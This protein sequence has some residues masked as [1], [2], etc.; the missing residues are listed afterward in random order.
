M[1][2][3]FRTLGFEI[4]EPVPLTELL[5]SRIP[6]LES[7]DHEERNGPTR[8]GFMARLTIDAGQMSRA[9][10][11]DLC[12]RLESGDILFFPTSPVALDEADRAFL[13][14]QKQSEAFHKN[15]S[16]RPG[17]D[18]LKGVDARDAA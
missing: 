13:L 2:L 5:E 15:I 6:H 8:E 7:L 4:P 3:R 18:R 17:P 1:E 14:R 11:D 10:S 9:A 12:A 16:Y